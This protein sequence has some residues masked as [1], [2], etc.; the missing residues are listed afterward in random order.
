MLMCCVCCLQD[1]HYDLPF[2]DG[3]AGFS[4][5]TVREKMRRSASLLSE[6]VASS[7]VESS[8]SATTGTIIFIA[9]SKAPIQAAESES[10]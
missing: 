5:Q 4:Q 1:G 3:I 6:R 7:E 2:Y 10:R 8:D 9:N